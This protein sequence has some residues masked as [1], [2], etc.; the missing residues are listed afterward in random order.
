[1][2]LLVPNLVGIVVAFSGKY[3]CRPGLHLSA[4]D[5]LSDYL[6]WQHRQ[7]DRQYGE[8]GLEMEDM[9]ENRPLSRRVTL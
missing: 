4:D 9:S 2:I 5:K 1:M 8:E 7:Q 3:K 6:T